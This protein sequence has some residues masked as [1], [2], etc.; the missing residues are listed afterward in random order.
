MRS[1]H[2]LAGV[3][4]VRLDVDQAQ[5]QRDRHVCITRLGAPMYQTARVDDGLQSDRFDCEGGVTH[6]R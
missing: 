1:P 5:A 3:L 4:C 2:P 6:R